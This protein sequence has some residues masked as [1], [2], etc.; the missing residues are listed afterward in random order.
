[1]PITFDRLTD[2]TDVTGTPATGVAPV[3]GGSNF[4]LTAIYTAAEV[5]TLLTGYATT[6]SIAGK[7]DALNATLSGTTYFVDG[8]DNTTASVDCDTGVATFAGLNTTPLPAANL[9]GSI[10]DA[11]LSAN[12]PLKDA[13]NTLSANAAASTPA[14]SVTG[15]PFAGTGT[16]SLPL[17]YIKP[18]GATASTTLSTAGTYL[19]VNGTGTSDL[20]NFMLNGTSRMNI[21]STGIVNFGPNC[22]WDGSTNNF[23]AFILTSSFWRPASGGTTLNF[24]VPGNISTA[25]NDFCTVTGTTTASTGTTGSGFYVNLTNSTTGTAGFTLIKANYSGSGTGSGTKL[26]MD[27]QVAGSSLFKVDNA[28]LAT[29]ASLNLGGATV[30]DIL[31][32]TATL[33]FA[34][35]D[36]SDLTITVTGAALGDAVSIGA[37]HGSVGSNNVFYG[38]VSAADTVTIRKTGSADPASG[39]FR[40]VVWKF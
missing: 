18:S 39:T 38:W 37:Q 24:Q 3:Y 31:T 7:A 10:A 32:A 36:P 19:G 16:T 2:L 27:L 35:A 20:C 40:A 17:V 6:A 9:T 5:D 11:R 25:N 22:K 23:Y 21:T 34:A 1:M 26:L 29:A 33:D 8:S 15:T 14:L 4:A 12:V 13:A 28:G 30:T